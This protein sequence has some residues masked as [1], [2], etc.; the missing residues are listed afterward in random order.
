MVGST[1][2]GRIANDPPAAMEFAAAM[3]NYI[4]ENYNKTAQCWLRMGGPTGQV[5][6]QINFENMTAL[7]KFNEKILEDTE[8]WSKVHTA[9]ERHLFDAAAFEDGIW[10]QLV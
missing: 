3:T 8:Y 10:R 6:W 7:E 2:I 5:V 1:R 9:Q 4:K